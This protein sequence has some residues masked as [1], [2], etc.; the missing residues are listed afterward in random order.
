M[1]ETD[2]FFN[3]HKILSA[4]QGDPDNFF[5]ECTLQYLKTLSFDGK[6]CHVN[7]LIQI[8]ID[9]RTYLAMIENL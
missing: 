7:Q 3:P 4:I 8:I 9:P 5:L 2:N 1:S 6:F